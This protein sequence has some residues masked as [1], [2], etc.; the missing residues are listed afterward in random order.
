MITP[1]N[2]K[3][4]NNFMVLASENLD[5]RKILSNF[6]STNNKLFSTQC[7]RLIIKNCVWDIWIR[8]YG[9][10]YVCLK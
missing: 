5:G 2:N 6:I 4:R 10:K 7:F 9:Y 1:K 8:L 3:F